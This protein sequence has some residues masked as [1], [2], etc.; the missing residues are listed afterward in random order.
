[1]KGRIPGTSRAA[2]GVRLSAHRVTAL[3]RALER[4]E[5]APPYEAKAEGELE[6]RLACPESA[7]RCPEIAILSTHAAVYLRAATGAPN[8]IVPTLYPGRYYAVTI[9]G[10]GKSK[11]TL[12]LRT[13]NATRSFSLVPEPGTHVVAMTAVE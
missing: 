13:A 5:P 7:A 2:D 4:G 11:A 12:T 8:A 1:M 9:G 6:A 3:L 10:D